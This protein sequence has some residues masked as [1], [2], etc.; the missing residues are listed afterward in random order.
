MSSTLPASAIRYAPGV[1]LR[2]PMVEGT[3]WAGFPSP[4]SDFQVKCHDLND[5]MVTHP[6]ATFFWHVRGT[7]MMEAGIS[8]GD[9]LVVTGPCRPSTWMW[10]WPRSM[11]SSR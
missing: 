10:W 6:A 2:L 8:D 11:A 9:M 3:V 4:A 1:P 5:L 7:S